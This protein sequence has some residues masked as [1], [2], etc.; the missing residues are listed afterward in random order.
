LASVGAYVNVGAVVRS[1]A[2]CSCRMYTLAYN[3][4]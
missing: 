4:L 1:R 2:T 3:L